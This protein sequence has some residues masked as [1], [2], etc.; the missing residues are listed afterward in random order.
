[1]ASIADIGLGGSKVAPVGSD[2]KAVTAHRGRPTFDALGASLNQ[3]LLDDL[4]RLVVT[5]FAKTMV[6]DAPLRIDHI[7][8]G[9]IF[10][11]EGAP[12]RIVAVDRHRVV[13]SDALRES[14]DVV[15]VLFELELGRVHA[16]HDQTLILVLV[17]PCAQVGQRAHPVDAGIGPEVDQYD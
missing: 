11:A 13:D 10:I 5:T 4:L 9:P 12:D 2:L 14:T 3:Q 1:G 16:D 17:R 15:D 6:A 8:G 7:K